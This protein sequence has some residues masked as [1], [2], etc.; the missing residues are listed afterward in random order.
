MQDAL[1]DAG[2][3]LRRWMDDGA[4]LYVCGSLAGMAQGVD[5]ALRELL[6]AAAVEALLMEGRLRRDVY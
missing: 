1:K 6:G 2:D 4:V 3:A 5:A